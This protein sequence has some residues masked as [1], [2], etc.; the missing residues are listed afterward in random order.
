MAVAAARR[1]RRSFPV[2]RILLLGFFIAFVLLP[3]YWMFNTS[4]KPSD[5]YLAIPPVWFPERADHR[6]L[7][8]RRSSPTAGSTA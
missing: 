7:H 6:P 8:A 2:A 4:I 5:D 1:P 3:L